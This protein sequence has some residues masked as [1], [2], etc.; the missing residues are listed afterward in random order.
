MSGAHRLRSP[1]VYVVVHDAPF[2]QTAPALRQVIRSAEVFSDRLIPV[3]ARMYVPSGFLTTVGSWVPTS[4]ATRPGRGYCAGGVPGVLV[5]DAV[6]V[7]PPTRTS[8]NC[9][10]VP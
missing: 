6:G 7:L 4:P 5:G 8:R 3:A 1:L 2:G 9:W 10:L